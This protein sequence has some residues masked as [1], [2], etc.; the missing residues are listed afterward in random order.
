MKEYR[1]N[2][3]ITREQILRYY[4]GDAAAVVAQTDDGL[5]VRFPASALRRYVDV[6]GVHGR[7]LLRVGDD[8]RLIALERLPG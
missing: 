6:A 7:F 4:S 2:L 8:H 5:T 1:F 3:D